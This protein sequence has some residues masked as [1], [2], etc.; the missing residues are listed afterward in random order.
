MQAEIHQT[1]WVTSSLAKG[2]HCTS[3]QPRAFISS[4]GIEQPASPCWSESV[5]PT[6]QEL[7]LVVNL[8]Y[9]L[10]PYLEPI[11]WKPEQTGR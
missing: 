9:A 3:P 11:A 1:V 10:G 6:F 2:E 8:L 7:V 5:D 4:I